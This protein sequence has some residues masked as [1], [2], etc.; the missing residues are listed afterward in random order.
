[1]VKARLSLCSIN[2]GEIDRAERLLSRE[3]A[4]SQDFIYAHAVDTL[5]NKNSV[6]TAL[7]LVPVASES[8]IEQR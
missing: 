6:A 7:L 1:M 4:G 3:L 5:E 8:R 2:G